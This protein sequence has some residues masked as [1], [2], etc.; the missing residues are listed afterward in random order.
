V[1]ITVPYVKQV[2]I[3]NNGANPVSAARMG[4]LEEGILDVSQAPAVHVFHNAAQAT[5]SGVTL[6]LAFNS[7][8]YDQA[9]GVAST[10][11]DTVTNNSRLTALYAGIYMI[12][13]NVEW[14]ASAASDRTLTIRL[15]AAT[16]IAVDTA[17]PNANTFRQQVA[18]IYSLAVNDFVE[19]NATQTTGGALNINST[20]N[21]SPEFMMSRVG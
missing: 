16:N 21:F 3:D 15:N 5:T 4:V 18:I 11:H 1:P 6:V 17:T 2:W 14:A 7:E 9:G 12:V 20:G 19:V 8:R 10:Q 13:C